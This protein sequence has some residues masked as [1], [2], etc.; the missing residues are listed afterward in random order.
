MI[1][2]AREWRLVHAGVECKM[3]ARYM[4]GKGS[5]AVAVRHRG[6]SWKI[7]NLSSRATSPPSY[8]KLHPAATSDPRASSFEAS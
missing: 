7:A 3:R 8:L 4:V 5:T 1:G 6:A 2:E